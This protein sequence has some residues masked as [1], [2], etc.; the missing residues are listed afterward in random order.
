VSR[1]DLPRARMV[2]DQLPPGTDPAVRRAM[3][4]VPRHLFVPDALGSVA[5]SD[6]PLPIGQNQTISQPRIVAR[7]TELLG[8][9]GDER[10]LEI[11]TGSGYQTAVLARLCARVVSVERVGEL[12]A[13]ARR[14]L[15]ELRLHNV[16]VLQADGT[17]G[18]SEYA[19]FDAILVTAGAPDV[20]RPLLGQLAEGGRL[21]VPVGDAETQVLVRI[22]R[23]GD[24]FE[25]EEFDG[26]RF[27]PLIG[28]FGWNT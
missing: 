6:R 1:Y 20:P 27:V 9:T 18:R 2:E 19:P 12:A 13:A 22:T 11:G 16:T 23:R 15:S 10:V 4:E 17:L 24:V 8:L 7:M 26:C 28:R 21:V 14:R 5:Y 3:A 25:R